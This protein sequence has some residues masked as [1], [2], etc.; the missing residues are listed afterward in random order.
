MVA[1]KVLKKSKS[2]RGTRIKMLM[3]FFALLVL[4]AA[5]SSCAEGSSSP[6]PEGPGAALVVVAGEYVGLSN[7]YASAR[8]DLRQPSLNFL[9][10]DFTGKGG[11]TQILSSPGLERED[12]TGSV[13]CRRR[14]CLGHAVR[15]WLYCT[16]EYFR[17]RVC[18]VRWDFDCPASPAVV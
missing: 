4:M 15:V 3:C 7:G 14:C 8:F 9:G 11:Y 12:S 5:W 18:A 2:A 13:C 10:A 6:G 16:V 1:D 17:P